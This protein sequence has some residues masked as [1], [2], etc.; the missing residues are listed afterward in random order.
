MKAL[1]LLVLGVAGC[2]KLGSPSGG[3]VD[4]VSPT[5]VDTW[6]HA[7]ATS[8]G[9]DQVVAIEF[10]EGMDRRLTEEALFI[11]PHTTASFG[12]RGSKL[13]I[14]SRGG[15]QPGQTYVVTVGSDARDLR[16]NRLDQSF[17]LAF[18]TGE[19]L[20]SGHIS[21]HVF[22]RAKPAAA[23]HVWAYD[24]TRFSGTA[25][26]D[27][28]AYRTQ[29]GV[30]G[31]YDFQRLATGRFRILAFEDTDKNGEYDA[32]EA[33]AV[34]SRDVEL[35]EQQKAR[36]ADLALTDRDATAP[37]LTRA[38]SLNS[39]SVLL[40]F[41]APVEARDVAVS[42]KG[43]PVEG[44]YGST[45][46][47]RVYIMTSAQESGKMYS[48]L[49]LTIKGEPAQWSDSAD[50]VDEIRGS[51]RADRKPPS[52]ERHTPSGFAVAA[53]SLRILFSEAMEPL[54][55]RRDFWI[56]SDSTL[57]LDGDWIWPAA[58]ELV[59]V[60]SA[61]MAAAAHRLEGRL[62]DL[63]DVAGHA[64]EDSVVVF[65]FDVVAALELSSISGSAFSDEA[66]GSST[67]GS[68]GRNSIRVTAMAENGTAA[69]VSLADETG[70]YAIEGLM[71]GNYRVF[72]YEDANENQVFDDGALNP[73]V[74]AEPY[75]AHGEVV[76]LARRG[77]A[78]SVDL[79]L[80]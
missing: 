74:A 71:P 34:P 68:D 47:K 33:L 54:A 69:H 72:A 75:F 79:G 64:C 61:P 56:A 6:P 42:L 62:H 2:A 50:R 51:G 49:E 65:Q 28:P 29:T 35:A 52:V 16:G 45:D 66:T 19:Q 30:D 21:G 3:E 7:D 58:N 55:V 60:P 38:Q 46:R 20:D 18:A 15:L 80:R 25:G 4:R 78:E 57:V 59:F 5:V 36:A 73:F 31:A 10:S 27:P 32:G 12:W 11:T 22:R 23:V 63:Q 39:N 44:V 67:V 70:S 77:S 41:D 53:D 9:P 14:R 26:K 17:T 24:M 37:R 40:V 43:L 76:S 13:E 48:L 1:P 8:V